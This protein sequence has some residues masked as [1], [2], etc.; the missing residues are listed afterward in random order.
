M[1]P[2]CSCTCMVWRTVFRGSCG[3]FIFNR[4]IQQLEELQLSC[5]TH[6]KLMLATAYSE[7]P[8]FISRH[9]VIMAMNIFVRAVV[10]IHQSLF[11]ICARK[12]AS[13][14]LVSTLKVDFSLY[15]KLCE[16]IF[17]LCTMM[18]DGVSYVFLRTYSFPTKSLPLA[19]CLGLGNVGINVCFSWW[20]RGPQ[21]IRR[22]W[23]SGHRSLLETSRALDCSSRTHSRYV[24]FN[25]YV[26]LSMVMNNSLA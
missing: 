20:S 15:C 16:I 6:Y 12:D 24:S 4:R 8:T 18:Y 26:L 10:F 11:G 17:T 25:L 19:L 21:A 14:W 3:T 13:Q 7:T 2:F 23:P 22:E 9:S 5:A 1:S